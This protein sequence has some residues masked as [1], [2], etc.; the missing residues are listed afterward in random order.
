MILRIE[1]PGKLARKD[2]VGVQ[3]T[4]LDRGTVVTCICPKTKRVVNFR[5]GENT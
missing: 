4:E 5:G 1:E 2:E 3:D